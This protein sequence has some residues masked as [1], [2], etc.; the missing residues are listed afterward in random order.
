M[1]KKAIEKWEE[2]RLVFM[3]EILLLL[4]HGPMPRS[5]VKIVFKN[6]GYTFADFERTEK[7]MGLVREDWNGVEFIR[8]PT[9][10]EKEES[11]EW[12]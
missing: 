9:I 12:A 2:S 5:Y 4:N 10:S 1:Q 8:K 3:S 11:E 6:K 7:F